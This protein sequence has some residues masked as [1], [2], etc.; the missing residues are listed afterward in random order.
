MPQREEEAIIILIFFSVTNDVKCPGNVRFWSWK[1]LEKSWNLIFR[2]L[3]EPCMKGV[4]AHI[5]M[6]PLG[7]PVKLGARAVPYGLKDAVDKA[8]NKLVQKGTIEPGQHSN[9]ATPI[10]PVVK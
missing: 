10:V 2:F 8:L 6:E 4:K 5:Q 7:K 9:W 1:V 3:W